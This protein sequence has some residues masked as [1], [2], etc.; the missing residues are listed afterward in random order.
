MSNLGVVVVIEVIGLL[1]D[2]RLLVLSLLAVVPDP[3]SREAQLVVQH[4]CR[5]RARHAALLQ[6]AW[7]LWTVKAGLLF[8]GRAVAVHWYAAG[9]ARQ[10]SDPILIAIKERKKKT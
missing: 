1:G 5:L 6:R 4:G 3:V 2:G 9:E 8:D 10:E 7:Q